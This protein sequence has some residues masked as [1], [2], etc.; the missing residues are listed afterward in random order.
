MVL[1]LRRHRRRPLPR[2]KG[3]LLVTIRHS[4]VAGG[5]ELEEQVAAS[6]SNGRWPTSSIQQRVSHAEN[7]F[8]W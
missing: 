6:G 4:F 8:A 2:T 7:N 3:L 5:D 1:G